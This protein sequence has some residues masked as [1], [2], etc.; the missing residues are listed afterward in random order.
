MSLKVSSYLAKQ[1]AGHGARL[2]I[3]CLMALVFV[4]DNFPSTMHL[5][6]IFMHWIFYF[7]LVLYQ[8]CMA[9]TP[10]DI[11]LLSCQSPSFL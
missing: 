6:V 4:L 11:Q 7:L 2:A 1:R 9:S 10:K 3:G 5:P 8:Q